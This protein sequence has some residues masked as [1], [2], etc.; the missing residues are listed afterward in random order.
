MDAWLDWPDVGIQAFFVCLPF[1][2][3]MHAIDGAL[4]GAVLGSMIGLATH[5]RHT[6]ES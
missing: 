4:V 1:E 6:T 3:A 2:L 5:K